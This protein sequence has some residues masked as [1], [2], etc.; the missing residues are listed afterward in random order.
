MKSFIK[1]KKVQ[2]QSI[3]VFLADKEPRCDSNLKKRFFLLKKKTKNLSYYR[4]KSLDLKNNFI[5]LMTSK[6]LKLKQTNELSDVF[7]LF[8]F[9]F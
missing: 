4:I 8:F 5:G 2:T 9:F 7:N 1:P 6:G 3:I